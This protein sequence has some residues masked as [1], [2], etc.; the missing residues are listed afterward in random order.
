MKILIPMAAFGT[1]GGARVLSQLANAWIDAGHEVDML[2]PRTAGHPYFPTRARILRTDIRGA[3]KVK[4]E[5]EGPERPGL[6][7][8]FAL[9]AG[10]ARIGGRY[11]VVLANHNLTAWAVALASVPRHARFYY[12]QAYEPTFCIDPFAPGRYALAR[13]SY[14]L[15]LTQIV[16]APSYPGLED[17]P[18]I[19]CGIDLSVFHRREDPV[20]FRQDTPI[21]LGT[22][23]RTEPWKGTRYVLEAFEQLHA[24]DP[25]YRLRVAFGNLPEGWSHSAADVVMPR[26]DVELAAFYRSVDIMVAGTYGLNDSPHYPVLEAMASGVPAVSTGYRPA[27]ESNSWLYPARDTAELVNVIA[28]IEHDP[29]LHEKIDRA[30]TAAEAFG[31]P[32]VAKAMER[33][34]SDTLQRYG[35]HLNQEARS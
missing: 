14:N 32:V 29:D 3:V 13:L 6:H 34:F 1:A 2:V 5:P 10:L 15:P 21:V 18:V 27:D 33:Q 23:G 31:W 17:R 25:R 22:I 16:N 11:D 19:S 12:I 4:A 30:R 20:R 35:R 8:N 7:N 28:G 24:R 9:R 26:G